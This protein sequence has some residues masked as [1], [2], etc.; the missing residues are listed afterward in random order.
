MIGR[1]QSRRVRRCVFARSFVMHS[2]LQ[3]EVS[4]GVSST[5]RHEARGGAAGQAQ[6]HGLGALAERLNQ[7]PVVQAQRQLQRAFD[8][9]PRGGGGR[10]AES[11]GLSFGG[12][13][14]VQRASDSEDEVQDADPSKYAEFD[15]QAHEEF[16]RNPIYR[17]WVESILSRGPVNVSTSNTDRDAPRASWSPLARQILIQERFGPSPLRASMMAFEVTNAL[18][19]PRTDALKA[20]ALAH[21]FEGQGESGDTLYARE[22]ERSEY[23]GLSMHHQMM[24]HGIQHL[25]W[26]A[27]LDRYGAK[28]RPGGDWDTFEKYLAQQER[29]GHTNLHRSNYNSWVFS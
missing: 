8:E 1:V 3:R 24:A 19:T 4:S 15:R 11:D 25:G 18:Q 20:R 16:L 26:P 23:D 28:L 17:Q 13:G 6:E 22:A 9:G 10:G 21:A 5:V 12:A 7:R 29:T 27:G 2:F 14:V